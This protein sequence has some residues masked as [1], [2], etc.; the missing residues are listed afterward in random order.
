M[1]LLFAIC[2]DDGGA[3]EA[4]RFIPLFREQFF[5]TSTPTTDNSLALLDKIY[6]HPSNHLIG[7]F[8]IEGTTSRRIEIDNT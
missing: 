7:Q 8:L 6:S 2:S 1:E 4:N 3:N 5:S